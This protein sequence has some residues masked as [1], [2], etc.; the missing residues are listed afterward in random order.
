MRCK[1]SLIALVAMGGAAPLAA[2]DISFARDIAPLLESQCAS[3]HMT[4][5]EPGKLALGSGKAYA[6]LVNHAASEAP[7]KRVTPGDADASY[8]LHKLDGT[9]SEAGGQGVRMGF[10]AKPLSLAQRQMIRA[11]ILAGAPNN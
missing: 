10:G 8:V 5:Q 2:A 4:G 9:H 1:L 6:S 11:W 3:C 7:M